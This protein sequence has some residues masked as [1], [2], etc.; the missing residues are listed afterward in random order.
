MSSE[1]IATIEQVSREK[2]IDPEEIVHA[3][4]DAILTAARKHYKNRED[5]SARFNRATGQVDLFGTKHVVDSV[6]DPE[7]QTDVESARQVNPEASTG[8]SV[9]V[10]LA[11]RPLGRIEAQT[12]K[13]IIFQRV[14]E[15]ERKKIHDEY[16]S[17]I[18]ELVNGIVK[19][20][21]KGDMIVDLGTTEA[22]LPKMYQSPVEHYSRGDRIR[23]V[24]AKVHRFS[25][26]PQIVL[27]R[28]DPRLLIKLFEAEVPEIYDGTIEI[29][30]AVREAGDR[31]K[32]AVATS[33]SEIDPV[34]A[35]VGIKGTRV[36]SVINELHGERIDIIEWSDDIVKLASNALKPAR[37]QQVSFI[38]E[39]EKR[40]EIIVENDQ[41]SLAIGKKGQNVRLA[42]KLTGWKI[43]IKSVDEHK[44]EQGERTARYE[45]F[46]NR[47][48]SD[49]DLGDKALQ[50]LDSAG[51]NS[52][53]KLSQIHS[54]S[55]ISE[56]EPEAA[57]KLFQEIRHFVET[58]VAS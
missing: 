26:D 53:D 2:G 52:L 19:N 40:L 56:L 44:K 51:I 46:R 13:Q 38:D 28:T 35:C 16:T 22:I 11:S 43:D 21:E 18:G 4:E 1:L 3:I 7:T 6:S 48:Q 58:G 31:A 29:K 8:D 27:S 49:P 23:A 37:V 57:E 14:K 50:A 17:R 34:G 30:S 12:A 15:A 32:I 20:F 47:I 55:D 5:L 33:A 42:S 24:I 36:Q 10:L 9:N 25:N 41:L 39:N 54:S 45:S